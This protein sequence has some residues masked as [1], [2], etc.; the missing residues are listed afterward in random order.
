VVEGAGPAAAARSRSIVG[1][2]LD[3][4]RRRLPSAAVGD[5]S[6][7]FRRQRARGVERVGGLLARPRFG[8]GE[9]DE[10][11]AHFHRLVRLHV[12]LLDAPAHR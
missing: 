3:A 7:A 1:A 2:L 5:H 6:L 10:D 4:G 12:N 8:V 11:G 9:G